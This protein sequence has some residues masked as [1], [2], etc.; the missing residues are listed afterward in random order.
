M[1]K[2]EQLGQ[3]GRER[4]VSLMESAITFYQYNGLRH[5]CATTSTHTGGAGMYLFSSFS[6]FSLSNRT[7]VQLGGALEL[8]KRPSAQKMRL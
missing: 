6:W 1:E 4:K 5:L 2:K 3:R 7:M 8:F